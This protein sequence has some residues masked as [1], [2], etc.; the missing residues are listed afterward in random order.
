MTQTPFQ[1]LSASATSKLLEGHA[2]AVDC[3]DAGGEACEV[4]CSEANPNGVATFSEVTC[5]VTFS[6]FRRQRPLQPCSTT[7]RAYQ[8]DED[9]AT[10]DFIELTV[11]ELD[12][13]V[14]AGEWSV[15]ARV[16]RVSTTFR[17]SV[18]KL[19]VVAG[20]PAY[21]A[22]SAT[23]RAL[24]PADLPG[25]GDFETARRIAD[26]EVAPF[27]RFVCATHN[28]AARTL[29]AM[30]STF[31]AP[32]VPRAISASASWCSSWSFARERS[33]SASARYRSASWTAR[34]VRP[35]SWTPR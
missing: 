26:K 4:D 28:Q 12:R 11:E 1:S 13:C 18:Q 23:M 31:G 9:F 3:F 35:R 21:R 24:A 22:V 19:G 25:A 8:A 2:H 14:T 5:A 27:R 32:I 15:A 29:N 10:G 6:L 30:G 33:L 17:R 7:L 16:L 20:S 34:P